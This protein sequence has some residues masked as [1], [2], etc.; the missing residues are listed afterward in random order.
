MK[1]AADAASPGNNRARNA[2]FPTIKSCQRKLNLM[3]DFNE[4]VCQVLWGILP[5]QGLGGSCQGLQVSFSPI[6]S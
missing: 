1:L 3:R 6:N 4:N 5:A 2:S